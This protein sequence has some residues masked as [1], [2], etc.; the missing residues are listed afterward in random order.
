MA[1]LDGSVNKHIGI[2]ISNYKNGIWKSEIKRYPTADSLK[3]AG[4]IGLEIIEG[5][6]VSY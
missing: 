3:P 6:R 2:C 1:I 4:S 5:Q